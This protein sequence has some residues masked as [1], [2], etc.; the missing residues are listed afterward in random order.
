VKGS[1]S[2]SRLAYTED[3]KALPTGLLSG[4]VNFSPGTG[5]NEL[6]NEKGRTS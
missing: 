3:E 4:L 5:E 1:C 2:N 6:P